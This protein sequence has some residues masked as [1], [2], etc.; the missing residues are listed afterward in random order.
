MFTQPVRLESR[1]PDSPPTHHRN[2][3]LS[4]LWVGLEKGETLEDWK[5]GRGVPEESHR[6][7]SESSC[8][9]MAPEPRPLAVLSRRRPWEGP[10]GQ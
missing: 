4:S 5:D 3:S 1:C 8:P 9:F 10:G 6:S 7:S 2:L